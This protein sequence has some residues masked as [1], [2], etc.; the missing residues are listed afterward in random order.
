MTTYRLMDGIGGRP[1][2][3]PASG[4][5]YAGNLVCGC[6]FGVTAGGLWFEGYY[7]WP[8]V[9]N[10]DTASGQKFA[11]WQV[12]NGT[13][14]GHLVPG[15]AVT[16]G[17]LTAGQ[18]NFVPLATPLLLS[19]CAAAAATTYGAVYLA[20]TGKVFSSGFPETK[21]QFGTGDPYAAGIT[22]GP[23]TGFSSIS[24]SNPA[25]GSSGWLAQ[26]PFSV[27]GSDPTLVYPAASD[28]DAN[29]WL[30]VQVSDQAPAGTQA[31]RLFPNIPGFVAQGL[32]TQT[33]AYT[34]GL[35]F[36]LASACALSKIWHYSPPGVSVLPT[37][38][39]IWD[40]ATQTEVSGTDNSSPSWLLPGGGAA[41]AGDG[42]VYCDYSGAGVTL[43]ASQ[44]YKA[45]TF[46][47]DNTDGWFYAVANF[48]GTSPDPFPSGVTAGPLTILGN[49]A[50]TIG[51]DSWN[52]GTSWAYPA[53]SAN[54]EYD[55]ID[56]EV[57]TAGGIP[58]TAAAALT[59]TPSFATT[60]VT[61]H[62]RGTALTIT[63]RFG[64][65][66]AGGAIRPGS[67]MPAL[68]AIGVC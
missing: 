27:G 35:E 11:L 9:T 67:I 33:T 46:T 41:A 23:L 66:T 17:A 39:G 65:T 50:S 62:H 64:V 6:A 49:A 30:D 52:H 40:V 32:G 36:T 19:P 56:I 22:N 3:G 61:A 24:G 8:P 18:W 58:R 1:G 29:L 51:Q 2:S 45:S 68:V 38:C 4:T 53:T 63:P 25:G 48:W 7:W 28:S 16:A 55:G 13:G 47:S 59:V 43:N 20:A 31:Y 10:G 57:S 26:M 5:S 44:N 37:R 42:W 15:S 34:L 14:A 60:G 12:D 21:N 54:P